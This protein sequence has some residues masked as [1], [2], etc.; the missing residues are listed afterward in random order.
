VFWRFL[1]RLG[2]VLML[3]APLGCDDKGPPGPTPSVKQIMT[4]SATKE[5]QQASNARVLFAHQSVGANILGGLG[6]LL[7]SSGVRWPI[8]EA[9]SGALPDGPALLE[10]RPGQN[11]LPKTKIDGFAEAIASLPGAKP[12]VAFMKLCFVDVTYESNVSE[13]LDYYRKAIDRLKAEHPD[14]V[15]GHVTVPLATRVNGAKDRVKRL[16]GRPVKEDFSNV[17]R[18]EYNRLL[19]AAFPADPLLDLERVES[20]HPDGTREQST[21]DGAPVL[22]LA[23]EYASDPWGHLNAVGSQLAAR[24]LVRFVADAL[25]RHRPASDAAPQ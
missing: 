1:K 19:R 11:G 18:Q 21:V 13:I 22:A 5:L 9:G 2:L 25:S 17:K 7:E 12:Q 3:V 8:V 23:P 24:E 6:T 15:F 20:T 10:I 16:V 14:I 4:D